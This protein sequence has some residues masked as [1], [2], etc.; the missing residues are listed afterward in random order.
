MWTSHQKGEGGGGGGVK[1]QY[2]HNWILGPVQGAR[3]GLCVFNERMR[4]WWRRSGR[5]SLFLVFTFLW[6][7]RGVPESLAVFLVLLVNDAHLIFFVI[8]FF[9][10]CRDNLQVRMWDVTSGELLAEMNGCCGRIRGLAPYRLSGRLVWT[11]LLMI[12][13]SNRMFITL[14][15]PG[16]DE[17]DARPL[18]GSASSDGS[19]FWKPTLGH[20]SLFIYWHEES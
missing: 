19:A 8:F 2:W 6:S 17:A 4:R 20:L 15:D 16:E 3:Y 18:L 12:M 10:C 14:L 9:K 7:W 11:R 13:A 1:E 5:L